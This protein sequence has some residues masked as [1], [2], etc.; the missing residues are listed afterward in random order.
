[1]AGAKNK[2]IAG[3]YEG[4]DVI[5]GGGKLDFMHRLQ[6]V[7]LNRTT[8]LKYEIVDNQNGNSFWGAFLKGYVSQA[9]LGT[10]GLVASTLSSAHHR[11]ILLSVEFI[12]GR[13]SLLEIDESV[14]KN[15]LKILY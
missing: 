10:A 2:V 1:M 14:Y 11:V 4:W 9:F 6:R 12:N 8:V 3:D 5:C 7:S 15:I 13:R